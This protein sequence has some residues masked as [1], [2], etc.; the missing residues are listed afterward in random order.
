MARDDKKVIG[1]VSKDKNQQ[2]VSIQDIDTFAKVNEEISAIKD[3][4]VEVD[5]EDYAM[6][7]NNLLHKFKHRN[8]F[9][10]RVSY[11]ACLRND[12][13]MDLI[14]EL[15]LAIKK[16]INGESSISG[17]CMAEMQSKGYFYD[18]YSELKGTS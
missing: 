4:D 18:G 13:R 11:D 6:T 17:K 14:K 5:N 8:G 9:V 7:D 1:V 10:L 3:I 16:S 12:L 2:Y 15:A